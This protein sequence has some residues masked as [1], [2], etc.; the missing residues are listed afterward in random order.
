MLA[1]CL[2]EEV[3]L[4]DLHTGEV[5]A[6][7]DGDGEVLTALKLTPTASHLVVC[8]RSLFMKVYNL[9]R[10]QDEGTKIRSVLQRTLKPH[11]APVT[12]A[13]I[14]KTGTLLATG[15]ADSV[16]KVWDI[17]GG[18]VTHTFRGHTGVVSA[19][20]FFEASNTQIA[21]QEKKNRKKMSGS[22]L[23]GDNEMENEQDPTTAFRLA[24]GG[25]DGK[26]RIWDLAKRKSIASLDAH[27]SVVRGLDFS[28]EMNT[29]VS[30]SRD[31]TVIVWNSQS[32]KSERIVPV[33]EV[34]E[35]VKFVPG[36]GIIATGG[37]YGRVRLWSAASGA[38][39]T[40]EQNPGGEG[41]VIVQMIHNADQHVL[42]SIH[43]DQSLVL[44]ST[45]VLKNPSPFIV[46]I[47]PLP[48]LR[49]ISGTH[50]EIID[51]AYVT[52]DR[53]L[54]AL[55]TN[56]EDVRLVSLAVSSNKTSDTD[57]P[58][59]FG[60]DV[61]LL[62]GHQ[63][64]IICLA[65]DWSG[66][67]LATGAKDNMAR[68]WRVDHAS[69]SYEHYATFTGH[70]E[71][72][73]AIS[74][75]FI[76]PQPDSH[77]FK[78]PLDHP[79]PF[80]LT[81]SQDRTIKRWIIPKST[82][83]PAHALYTRKAHDKDI[84]A[85][86]L[87]STSHLFASASQDRTV[88]IWSTEEGEAQGVLRGHKRGVWSVAFAPRDTPAIVSD[89]GPTAANRGMILTGSGDK[90][91]KIWSLNDY[92]CLRTFE[93]H[94][95]NVLKVLWLPPPSLSSQPSQ[96]KL[97]HIASAGADG[98]LKIWDPASGEC[99]TT[100]DNHTD[101]IWALALNPT[102]RT[103]VSGGA[104][105]VVTFWKD[106]TMQTASLREKA[107]TD[108]VEQDQELSNYMHSGQ[109]REAIA[110]ALALDHP[111][112]LLG[113]FQSVLDTVPA[114]EGSITGVK[115]V[116]DVIAGLED[117]Q[118]LKLLERVRDW[119]TNA[120]TCAVAQRVLNVIVRSYS[121]ERLNGLAKRRGGMDVV[122]ALWVYRERHYRRVEE[123]WEESWVVE[124]LLGEMGGLIGD[125]V[126]KVNSMEE[127]DTVMTL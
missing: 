102:T 17:R 121:A 106:T 16:V 4:T 26:I 3:L 85:L 33:L 91:V 108:R 6:R 100:L 125:G 11:A 61:A 99:L 80:L 14:D 98:L 68:L 74:I 89:N 118:L 86:A 97:P 126:E 88:K 116:D 58:Q 43:N 20:H 105:A 29:L 8:S 67:W 63:D 19:L 12:T 64:I 109:Y 39:I 41:N 73:G 28:P 71:T 101:R 72:I 82:S 60:A 56:S 51:L 21:L 52:Q 75:P 96:S 92:S 2:G 122:E 48:I 70:A 114:E 103:L 27:A 1:T 13:T 87:S 127:V 38:E 110:L 113:F 34:I 35:A 112:R 115:A 104:D 7:I 79:P 62:Q 57:L 77:A 55:A 59:Y 94:T 9:Q 31:K 32:W 37:E 45:S 53:S 81:G 22:D 42:M 18:Y 15:G 124:F 5:L 117:R 123:L 120:R 83:M 10:Q 25:E 47:E 84:N 23:G 93:G 40:Q 69:S 50:D 95:N 66:C 46:P 24:S 54:L 30:A 119:N 78:S 49:T 65:V 44:H 90:T 111:A 107:A 76:T 36:G